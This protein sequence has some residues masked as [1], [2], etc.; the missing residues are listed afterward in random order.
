[1]R[2]LRNPSARVLARLTALAVVLSAALVALTGLGHDSGAVRAQTIQATPSDSDT[3]TIQVITWKS[4]SGRVSL[5]LYVTLDGQ[6]GRQLCP[7]QRRFDYDNTRERRWLRTT[8]V[9][10][11]DDVVGWI[12]AR[13]VGNWI[14]FV[15]WMR[16]GE[17]GE[18]FSLRDSDWRLHYDEAVFSDWE[19][20]LP[21]RVSLATG[22]QLWTGVG[23]AT[24]AER[25]ERGRPAPEF[26][27]PTLDDPDRLVSLSEA[28]AGNN[29]LTL[30]VFWA[31]YAP[32]ARDTLIVLADLAEEADA[33]LISVNVYQPNA[34]DALALT[35]QVKASMLHL[36]DTSGDVA[37]HYRV[38]GLPEIF[39]LDE[40]GVYR[41]VVRGAAPRS[42]IQRAIRIAQ[43]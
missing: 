18:A 19:F 40:K 3:A 36:E 14:E 7:R 24:D 9:T 41:E 27:L 25:L 30:I 11:V 35:E 15:V 33:T 21:L 10:I 20:S 23:I 4:R 2:K 37:Q 16:N 12:R 17:D 38:D 32:F 13:K 28:R 42:Q 43:R 26:R 29:G 5:C 8:E 1:M 34:D 22:E 39:V 6:P 31:S